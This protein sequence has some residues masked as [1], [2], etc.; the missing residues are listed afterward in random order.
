[1]ELIKTK[2]D[3]NRVLKIEKAKLNIKRPF[4]MWISYSEGYRVYRFFK[5]LRYLEFYLN[6]KKNPWD[7]LPLAWRY[8][9]HRRMKLKFSFYIHPNTLGEGF[10][11]VHSG[12]VRIAVF[13]NIGKN[14]TVL[15]RVLIGK[16]KPRIEDPRVLIGEDCY[17]G[18]GV[19][20]LGPIKIGNNVTIAAGSVVTH[21]VPDNCVIGG[22]PAKIIKYKN[23]PDPVSS[24]A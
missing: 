10:H 21:D 24:S 19:T 22:I 8:W 9:N 18:T 20:I 11:L 2:E 13:A 1:M 6:K 7:Y 23:S 17:I 12:F 14:C 4:L 16:K 5:N 15:P 3:L